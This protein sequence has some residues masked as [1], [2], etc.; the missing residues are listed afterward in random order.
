MGDVDFRAGLGLIGPGTILGYPADGFVSGEK[1]APSPADLFDEFLR[2]RQFSPA[3]SGIPLFLVSEKQ[4][5]RFT[6]PLTIRSPHCIE[7]ST[8]DLLRLASAIQVNPKQ[9]LLDVALPSLLPQLLDTGHHEVEFSAGLKEASYPDGI[10]VKGRTRMH[11]R[12][13]IHH[14]R[15]DGVLSFDPF[16]I[17]HNPVATLPVYGRTGELPLVNVKIAKIEIKTDP[18]TGEVR[19]YVMVKLPGFHIVQESTPDIGKQLLGREWRSLSGPMSKIALRAVNY[20]A[21]M[22]QGDL[23]ARN[24]VEPGTE[25]FRVDIGRV[26]G[27][28]ELPPLGEVSRLRINLP[29]VVLPAGIV[30]SEIAADVEIS[31]NGRSAGQRVDI[32]EASIGEVQ[33]DPGGTCNG[34]PTNGSRIS[35]LGI[36]GLFDLQKWEGEGKFYSRG[37]SLHGDVVVRP[38]KGEKAVRFSLQ[39]AANGDLTLIS[40]LPDVFLS[41]HLTVGGKL[42]AG[43]EAEVGVTNLLLR[44]GEFRLNLKEGGVSY[45]GSITPSLA[46]ATFSSRDPGRQLMAGAVLNGFRCEPIRFWG[47]QKKIDRINIPSCDL[48]KLT[49]DWNLPTLLP[50]LP[51]GMAGFEFKGLGLTVARSPSG[52]VLERFDLPSFKADLTGDLKG[53]SGTLHLEDGLATRFKGGDLPPGLSV[54]KGPDGLLAVTTNVKDKIDVKYSDLNL[55]TGGTFAGRLNL[56]PVSKNPA[57]LRPVAGSLDFEGNA[58]TSVRRAW[59]DADVTSQITILD[60]PSGRVTVSAPSSVTRP[61]PGKFGPDATVDLQ[62]SVKK[63]PAGVSYYDKLDSVGLEARL[64]FGTQEIRPSETTTITLKGGGVRA[65]KLKTE[66]KVGIDIDPPD[67]LQV[68]SSFVLDGLTWELSGHL[69]NN[70][71]FKASLDLKQ[72][73]VTF[74]QASR[75]NEPNEPTLSGTLNLRAKDAE[76]KVLGE[77]TVDVTTSYEVSGSANFKQANLRI[78]IPETGIIGVVKEDIVLP[79][80]LIPA[81]S[82]FHLPIKGLEGGV[83]LDLKTLEMQGTWTV[84]DVPSAQITLPE[85]RLGDKTLKN[86]TLDLTTLAG[87]RRWSVTANPISK[88]FGLQTLPGPDVSSPPP[89]HFDLSARGEGKEGLSFSVDGDSAF[90]LATAMSGGLMTFA[91]TAKTSLRLKPGAKLGD[92]PALPEASLV[93]L[94][95]QVWGSVDLARSRVDSTINL[96]SAGPFQLTLPALFMDKI[97]GGRLKEQVTIRMAVQSGQPVRLLADLAKGKGSAAVVKD[98]QGSLKPLKLELDVVIGGSSWL[99]S[100]LETHTKGMEGS[101]DP[102]TGIATLVIK[103]FALRAMVEGRAPKGGD[104]GKELV[105]FAGESVSS[106]LD[107]L[108]IRWHTKTGLVQIDSKPPQKGRTEEPPKT[109]EAFQA[110][111]KG[112]ELARYRSQLMDNPHLASASSG[113][114]ELLEGHGIA[115]AGGGVLR[116]DQPPFRVTVDPNDPRGIEN[117]VKMLPKIELRRLDPLRPPPPTGNEMFAEGEWLAHIKSGGAAIK[118]ETGTADQ[119]SVFL[120]RD[121]K[122]P[123]PFTFEKFRANIIPYEIWR[124]LPQVEL[125]Y[126]IPVP[127]KTDE[128]YLITALKAFGS[129]PGFTHAKFSQRDGRFYCEWKKTDSPEAMAELAKHKDLL[130]EAM[131]KAG[132]SVSD[133]KVDDYLQ[134]FISN[135][136]SV[137]TIEGYHIYDPSNGLYAYFQKA[138]TT[139][140]IPPPDTTVLGNFGT[141]ENALTTALVT[142][143]DTRDR[144]SKTRI[145]TRVLEE[146]GTSIVFK[147]LEPA[148]R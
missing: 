47:N 78:R 42:L 73:K 119:V 59:V 80:L 63:T 35:G 34:E 92:L 55:K 72:K 44:D 112:G 38:F 123:K 140:I 100:D 71:S 7:Q 147:Q 49:A 25:R 12:L 10:E 41:S 86:V 62:S 84:G 95:A 58:S 131:S 127:G 9:Y 126:H 68:D 107:D 121:P 17:Q 146:D 50:E 54:R 116:V 110:W 130:R 139:A 66:E 89:L 81:G 51:R 102:V 65:K 136:S 48:D 14:G 128:F 97:T 109:Y 32:R 148:H 120:Y 113:I 30:V 75:P 122:N 67:T 5:S 13:E 105:K 22:S 20:F 145:S 117:A 31:P 2:K 134:D 133:D 8:N 129:W 60:D 104:S 88:R 96:V 90:D 40:H 11:A 1:V 99:S 103:S 45:S 18:A 132:L 69:K 135:L 26:P 6:L 76:G 115:P 144:R 79:G 24:M 16:I 27:Q 3:R 70:S 64:P 87:G 106:D 52:P 39:G 36:K 85:L 114:A 43:V 91:H 142:I 124:H 108:Q 93:D 37:V 98:A 101:Y 19:F 94:A 61:F 125:S 15:L 138:E 74:D 111:E 56:V 53:Y 77:G 137:K 23:G 141:F 46:L 21:G 29:K 57:D 82:K 118:D 33:H 4:L 143:G 83:V 28:K